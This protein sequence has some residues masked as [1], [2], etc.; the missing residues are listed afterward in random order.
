M[1]ASNRGQSSTEERVATR[2]IEIDKRGLKSFVQGTL[3][4]QVVRS[5]K[6]RPKQ[7]EPIGSVENLANGI[8]EVEDSDS[9]SSHSVLVV[10]NARPSSAKGAAVLAGKTSNFERI[11]LYVNG[12]LTPVDILEPTKWD[13]RLQPIWKC[14]HETCLPYGLYSILIHEITHAADIFVKSLKYKPSDVI[15]RG[16]A[17]WDPYVNDPAEVRAFMQEVVDVAER[18]APMFREHAK[19]NQR[20]IDMVLKMSTTW[21]LIEKHLTSKSKARILKAVYEVLDRKGLLLESKTARIVARHKKALLEYGY[22]AE[23][24]GL[25][26]QADFPLTTPCAECGK[27]AELALVVRETFDH[28]KTPEEQTFVTDL[29]NN[30][31]IVDG[32]R[33][34][35]L[36]DCAAFATYI[37]R[38]FDCTAATTL[39][40]Q[41]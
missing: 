34:F 6:R 40:N 24:A 5:L 19:T 30:P 41:A 1:G 14:T 36:H 38:D 22:G 39:W 23:G 9:R 10:V 2:P 13:D 32:E 17:A 11:D 21:G 26:E 33:K 35:W 8:L 15:E 3:I 27:P 4:P 29:H 18:H 20:L 7:N 37:C 31:E 16:E 28:S 12:A 25:S